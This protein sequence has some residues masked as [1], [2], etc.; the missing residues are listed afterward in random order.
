MQVLQSEMTKVHQGMIEEEK[1]IL[2]YM[3]NLNQKITQMQTK[4]WIIPA[5]MGLSIVLA[6][7]VGTWG[8]SQ[9][10]SSQIL[11]LQELKETIRQTKQTQ[12]KYI[13][14]AWSNAVGVKSKPQIWEDQKS[15]L[16]IVQY[17]KAE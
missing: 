5:V 17:E 11:A 9:Y 7:V 1:Q 14:K 10:L 8:V 2:Q 6:L 3:Q 16:W 12:D 15:G 4:Q 13:K